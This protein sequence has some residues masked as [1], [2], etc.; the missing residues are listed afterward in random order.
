MPNKCITAS[1]DVDNLSTNVPVHETIK[2]IIENVYNHPQIPPPAIQPK[3]L[4]NS[5]LPAPQKSHSMIPLA[6]YIFKLTVFW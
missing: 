5:S 2:I 4:E 1:L 3:I 6:T